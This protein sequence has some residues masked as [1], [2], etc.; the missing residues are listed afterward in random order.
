MYC[1]SDGKQ[2]RLFTAHSAGLLHCRR[3]SHDTVVPRRCANVTG[4]YQLVA[5]R[6]L[7][8]HDGA[9]PPFSSSP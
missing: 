7:S 5:E 1:T 6:R 2:H 3:E 9:L 8:L 4:C